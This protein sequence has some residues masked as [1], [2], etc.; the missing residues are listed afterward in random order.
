M[1]YGVMRGA[2]NLLFGLSLGVGVAAAEPVTIAALGDSL[3]QGYGLPVEDGF[4]PQLEA[5][6]KAQGADVE[7]IN[8]GVS[9]D[10]TAGGLSRVAWTLT[11]DV[12]VMIV[13]LGGNDLLRGIDPAVS[14]ANLDGI[15]QAAQEAGVD[16]LLVGLDAPGNY[17]PAYEAAFEG[18]Y[19][20]LSA[21]YGT[22]FYEN[23]FAPL[24]AQQ[25]QAAARR[26]FMQADGIHPSAAGVAIIVDGMGPVVMDLIAT[27][28]AE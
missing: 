6:L 27:S 12:D 9:G 1:T 11:P 20:D 18:M 23:F 24:L 16:V 28:S 17:G 10:T 15:L 19:P 7:I 26:M 5:W 25:D 13:T 4:V 21:T 8:A 3:T 14:R 2:R 22:A